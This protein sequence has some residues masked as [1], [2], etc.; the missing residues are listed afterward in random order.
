[1]NKGKLYVP[2][3]SKLYVAAVILAFV[4]VLIRPIVEL[5][6]FGTT[7]E[8]IFEQI[9]GSYYLGYVKAVTELCI[10]VGLILARKDIRFAAMGNTAILVFVLIGIFDTI[11][12]I[13]L[14]DSNSAGYAFLA[15]FAI[16]PYMFATILLPNGVPLLYIMCGSRSKTTFT[17]LTSVC[18]FLYSMTNSGYAPIS[19]YFAILGHSHSYI[20]PFVLMP[21]ISLLT[22]TSAYICFGL[23]LRNREV[24]PTAS[25]PPYPY[26]PYPF[27]PQ[28][29]VQYPQYY[30]PYSPQYQQPMV[31]AQPV[32]QPVPMQ[33][34]AQDMAQSTEQNNDQN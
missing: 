32:Q 18:M 14:A 2:K 24:V 4:S 15:M 11:V 29:P 7:V 6:F 12:Q 13:G 27:N 25:Y 19:S 5:I 31:Y 10:P 30:Q 1:M 22:I 23:S 28:Y 33:N 17:V 20:I 21:V 3:G 26:Q 8:N 16:I 34:N 9:A